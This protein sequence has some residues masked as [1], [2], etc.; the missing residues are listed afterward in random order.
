MRE[1]S[2]VYMWTHKY[3]PRSTGLRLI[4]RP[5]RMVKQIDQI[6]NVDAP[7]CVYGYWFK[8]DLQRR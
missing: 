1:Q 8:R 2:D 5:D 6:L 7:S 3:A 4:P